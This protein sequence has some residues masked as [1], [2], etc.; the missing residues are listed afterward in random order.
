[1]QLNS[2]TPGFHYPAGSAPFGELDLMVPHSARPGDHMPAELHFS[3]STVISRAWLS[4]DWLREE[5]GADM[6]RSLYERESRHSESQPFERAAADSAIHGFHLSHHGVVAVKPEPREYDFIVPG[7]IIGVSDGR[8]DVSGNVIERAYKR[9]YRPDKVYAAVSNVNVV[10]EC[11][12][13]K[14]GAA[15]LDCI[16]RLMPEDHPATIYA[17]RSNCALIA[18]LA[19]VGYAQTGERPRTDLVRGAVI[20]EVRMQADSVGEVRA[21]LLKK[22]SW[23]QDA[24]PRV[25]ATSK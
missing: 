18:K 10:P 4:S 12:G 2:K 19:T 23:L 1:M 21:G 7:Q 11:Q 25:P 24:V 16:L 3:P 5:I 15:L 20:N 6:A 9:R 8:M 14:I 17:S 22:F 13:K